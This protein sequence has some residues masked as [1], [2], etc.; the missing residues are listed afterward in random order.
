MY[1][2]GGAA[3]LSVRQSAADD[4]RPTML[5]GNPKT[6][7]HKIRTALYE[8]KNVTKIIIAQRLTSVMQADR[9]VIMEDG[10][11][12]AV[13]THESLLASDPVYQEIY[14]SQMKREEADEA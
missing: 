11:I 6:T 2:R 5:R 12:H 4:S 1:E 3:V 9:I 7:E 13:G 10:R 14:A 8:L